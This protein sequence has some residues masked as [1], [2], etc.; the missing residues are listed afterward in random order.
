MYKAR[1]LKLLLAMGKKI[2]IV[3]LTGQL[4]VACGGSGGESASSTDQDSNASGGTT[5]TVPI[6]L[7]GSDKNVMTGSQVSLDGSNSSDADGDNLTYNWFFSSVPSGSTALLTNA[8]TVSPNFTPDLDGDYIASL[9]VNDGKANSTADSVTISSSTPV[10]SKKSYAIVDTNQITCYHSST[11]QAETCTGGGTDADYSGNQPSYTVSS[12]GLSVTD[13]VTDLIWTQSTDINDDGVVNYDDKLYQSEAVSYCQDLSISGRDDWR[14]PNIKESYSLILFSGKDPS[15]YQ[16]TDASDFVLFLDDVFDNVV[17][18]I[19]S[20]NDRL[21]DGQYAS[22]TLYV[23]TTMNGDAT[24][25]GVN[26]VDGR[27]KGYPTRT[28]EYFVR[29]VA[30]NTAYGINDFV[31]N[32]DLTISDNA[33]E[34][35][36]QKNDTESSNWDDAIS[37]CEA[38][39]TASHSDW[40]LPNAKEL[41]SILDYTRSPDTD[42]S[43]AIDPLFSASSF[44]NEEGETD[45]GYYWASTTHVNYSNDGSNATYVSFGRALG[46]MNNNILDVHGAGSQRSNDKIAV[47]TE[48]GAKTA[49]GVN[50]TYYYKGPQGDIL[51]DNNKI[52]C[53]RDFDA[54]NSSN[55]I[56]AETKNYTL[57][58]PMQ[59]TD[60]FLIDEQG[61]TVHTW[62]SNY[63]PGLSVYLLDNGEL[64]RSGTVGNKP[65]TFTGPYGG[66]AGVIEIL[67]WDSNV[68]WSKTLATV[69]YLSHHDVEELPNGNIL[70]IVWE[71]KT[72]AQAL[73]LG[74][75]SASDETLWA[76]A[77]YEICRTSST[78][79]C[80][81]G[82]IVWQ[83]SSWD[84]V[85]QD[86]D[87]SISE[88]YVVDINENNHK[89]NLNYFKGSGSADWTHFNSVDYN[90]ET[91]QIL[92]SV[93]GFSEFWI[94]DH[95]DASQGILTRVGNPS[96]YDEAGE[97]VLFSQH[98]AQWI[99][100]SAPSAGNILVFNN[101]QNRP[102]GNYSSVDEFCFSGNS[103]TEGELVSSYFE[104]ATG[105]F[106]ADHISGAQRLING[107]TLVCDGTAGRLF[108][109]NASQE[110]VWEFDYGSEIFRA[111]RYL[112][113]YA[114]LRQLD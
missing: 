78:N 55:N 113:D 4:I 5:N 36:W 3:L 87:S 47:S 54:T 75:T 58:S 52:R 83:W 80:T 89:I 31:D 68:V 11:G 74:R 77:I 63:R 92:V 35:M 29:C 84:H 37:Q 20:G 8:A 108:E 62:E 67:D 103:C 112:G 91:E 98:D 24:M 53:V 22:S 45:W 9:I 6:A 93:H 109:Y 15:S 70:A 72:A 94:I 30:G 25:F 21:I 19:E 32:G 100:D 14:L 71:A 85:V 28:K 111:T 114:G 97:Q 13:N 34:L 105:D 65:A 48:P 96:A 86:V 101:G 61:S 33:T 12:D 41:Q 90:P 50:G 43:A 23:S 79:N 64:L 2:C 95:N 38:E 44:I 82:E 10:V 88:T 51:R 59:S 17:G 104:G 76:D 60:T 27:I 16:G 1:F 81:D 26:Y 18:D 99:E 69:N 110:I 56:N 102:A 40:R 7:A 39:T 106:Y 73:A 46:N 49:T 42:G 57:F 66:S 107:N